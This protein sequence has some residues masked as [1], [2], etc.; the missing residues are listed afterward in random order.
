MPRLRAIRTLPRDW[1]IALFRIFLHVGQTQE[2]FQQP[3]ALLGSMRGTILRQKLH[4]KITLRLQPGS[5][6]GI[7]CFAAAP[8]FERAG[9]A[10]KRIL[11]VMAETN[12]VARER[13]GN[14]V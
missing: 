14:S 4:D 3:R 5:R 6:T 10:G 13:R 7:Q 8:H 12:A 11:Q 2:Q 1:T 9:D